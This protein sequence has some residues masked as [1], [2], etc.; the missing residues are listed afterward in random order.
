MK[1]E[2]LGS[3]VCELKKIEEK[4]EIQPKTNIRKSSFENMDELWTKRKFKIVVS[5]CALIP[6]HNKLQPSSF[7][8]LP[9]KKA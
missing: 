3:S 9:G 4:I 6:T 1:R 8:C 2:K 5:A 7:F